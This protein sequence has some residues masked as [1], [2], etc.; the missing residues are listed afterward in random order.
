MSLGHRPDLC[1][2]PR[3]RWQ[4]DDREKM[5]LEAVYGESAFPQSYIV[6]HL[7]QSFG[8]KPHQIRVWFQNRCA[9]PLQ[10]ELAMVVVPSP[11]CVPRY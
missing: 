7:A 3:R 6:T 9:W 8:V 4:P 11:P 1:A 2:G 5:L 10:H